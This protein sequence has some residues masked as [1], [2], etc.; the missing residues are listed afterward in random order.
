MFVVPFIISVVFFVF[1]MYACNTADIGEEEN[2]KFQTSVKHLFEEKDTVDYYNIDDYI[3]KTLLPNFRHY[4]LY[5]TIFGYQK[6]EEGCVPG[7]IMIVFLSTKGAGAFIRYDFFEPLWSFIIALLINVLL[8]ILILILFE[9]TPIF[10]KLKLKNYSDIC[11]VY[12]SDYH[13]KYL[14]EIEESVMFR[15]FLRKV[16]GGFAMIIFLLRM[17]NSEPY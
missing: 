6:R 2:V 7:F 12:M 8:Y 10:N 16:I 13:Y 5:H 14:K 9:Y 1:W 15:Y 3:G 11:D 4:E 17:W